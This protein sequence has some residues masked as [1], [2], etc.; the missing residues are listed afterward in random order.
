M[1]VEE[2]AS[3]HLSQWFNAQGGAALLSIDSFQDRT[4]IF[5]A[6]EQLIH[7]SYPK[8]YPNSQEDYIFIETDS[9]N[10]ALRG[11]VSDLSEFIYS[12]PPSLSLLSL[13]D[14]FQACLLKRKN[15]RSH[16]QRAV[17][18]PAA[19]PLIE[20]E[21]EEQQ[22]EGV[23]M[24][25]DEYEYQGSSDEDEASGAQDNASWMDEHDKKRRW[26]EQEK[27]YREE[28]EKA[29]RKSKKT[30]AKGQ[31]TASKQIFTADAS[32][33]ILISD[34]LEIQR[35]QSEAHVDVSAVADNIYHWRAR[36]DA[37]AFNSDGPLASDL[38]ALKSKFGYSYVDLELTFT[39]DLYPFYPPLVKLVRP[40]F[41]GFM[42]GRVAGMDF[43]QLSNWSP[44]R[45]MKS[46]LH[47]IKRAL[48]TWGRI[49]LESPLNDIVAHPAGS[50]T[51]LE[52]ILT[53]LGQV[54]EMS[55]K[56][57]H[58]P[59]DE[60]SWK[61]LDV[62]EIEEIKMG[63]DQSQQ[64]AFAAPAGAKAN[65][66]T[67]AASAAAVAAPLGNQKQGSNRG[68]VKMHYWS[69]GTGYGH[70]SAKSSWDVKAY[71]AAQKQKDCLLMELLEQIATFLGPPLVHATVAASS[72]E[73][74]ATL[75]PGAEERR[76][77]AI[78][79]SFRV[80]EE[81]CLLPLLCQYF[82]NDSLL[83][84]QNHAELYLS[85]IKVVKCMVSWQ[86]LVPLMFL[87]AA[88]EGAYATVN[89]HS[90]LKLLGEAAEVYRKK[91][92]GSGEEASVM[93]EIED[94][95][96][97][98]DAA[99][100]SSSKESIEAPSEA[101]QLRKEP[102]VDEALEV[103]SKKMKP[104]QYTEMEGLDKHMSSAALAKPTGANSTLARVKRLAQEH[105]SLSH[106]LPLSLSSSIFVVADEESMDRTQV[107]IIGPE[108]TPYSTGCFIFDVS[109]PP[110]YPHTP[111][112]F[113]LRTTG[114][115]SVRFNPNLY[116]NGKVCLSLLGTWEGSAGETWNAETSTL[117]QVLV[118]IQSLILVPEPYFN[119]PGYE[120]QLGT[121]EGDMHNRAYN[122]R[123]REGSLRWAVLDMIKNPPPVFRDA[124][125]THFYLRRSYLRAQISSWVE[126]AKKVPEGTPGLQQRLLNQRAANL[127]SLKDLAA[128]VISS[129]SSGNCCALSHLC[130]AA[131]CHYTTG[132]N[133]V[134]RV[135]VA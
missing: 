109:F 2:Q 116:A 66:G 78:Q 58:V 99:A 72:H 87:P 55:P 90:K 57:L 81:S 12:E 24:S 16:L 112:K 52:H 15:G 6:L 41:E 127:E 47:G 106:S 69:K 113:L 4:I 130:P 23:E 124:I 21:V 33:K 114:G 9:P 126:E 38:A 76:V 14:K 59:E 98:L 35:G 1:G 120:R 110:Q 30:V 11:I 92:G 75:S 86:F 26:E 10:P 125:R 17:S 111:P 85:F 103:Y 50:Y 34:L 118:S 88:V 28:L 64:L 129:P 25:E 123:I 37:A 39:I 93:K 105:A 122:A 73:G 79:C 74:E 19:Q 117:L 100:E 121:P 63:E 60:N 102:S 101:A 29:K 82:G 84:I 49:D 56:S 94:L 48:E 27:A 71:L 108:D 131:C 96:V 43:L 53:K 42:V 62:Q 104:F 91:V 133:R 5:K 8:G 22:E 128:K 40:H 95:I 115:G 13:L 77:N 45:G 46:V 20:A 119:E 83:D 70:S 67:A 7:V 132:G 31:G 80:I 135:G 3:S 61:Q 54:T 68:P 89:V 32:S 36:F 65:Q 107:M 44:I 97:L 18:E 51:E 134:S